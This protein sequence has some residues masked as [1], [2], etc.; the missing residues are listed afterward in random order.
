MAESVVR[1][2]E[3]WS[4][5]KVNVLT[6]P[7]KEQLPTLTGRLILHLRITPFLSQKS[8]RIASRTVREFFLKSGAVPELCSIQEILSTQT[9]DRK[10]PFGVKIAL[11]T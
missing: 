8:L 9:Q 10:P 6:E 4:L 11:K 7:F 1:Q 5:A 2:K 3:T